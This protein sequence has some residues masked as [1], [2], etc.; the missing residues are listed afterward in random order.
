VNNEKGKKVKKKAGI[1]YH[2]GGVMSLY[3]K[4]TKLKCCAK[5][6]FFHQEPKIKTATNPRRRKK[7]IFFYAAFERKRINIKLWTFGLKQKVEE[8]N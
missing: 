6:G 3:R 2:G 1:N 4:K 5:F 8:Q 7:T